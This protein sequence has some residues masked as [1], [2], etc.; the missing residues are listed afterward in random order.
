MK[1]T[2][3]HT[4]L[5]VPG[6]TCLGF[7]CNIDRAINREQHIV[8]VLTVFF[9]WF[10]LASETRKFECS[11][12]LEESRRSSR[13]LDDLRGFLEDLG[14]DLKIVEGVLK[15]FA[16]ILKIFAG[17][18]EIFAGVLEIFAG[19]ARTPSLHLPLSTWLQRRENLNENSGRE[20]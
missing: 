16:G 6:A 11:I 20:A 5:G 14:G 4:D 10:I 19:E 3:E 13:G 9:T 1:Y 15:I 7:E 2:Q 8:T 18:L 12:G 17:I